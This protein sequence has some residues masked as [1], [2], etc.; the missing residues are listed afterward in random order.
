MTQLEEEK[1]IL[2]HPWLTAY[3]PHIDWISRKVTLKG[4]TIPCSPMRSPTPPRYQQLNRIHPYGWIVLPH[5]AIR[6]TLWRPKPRKWKMELQPEEFI[7]KP[8]LASIKESLIPIYDTVPT[9]RHRKRRRRRPSRSR[10]TESLLDESVGNTDPWETRLIINSPEIKLD[11]PMEIASLL[12][13]IS[14]LS[15]AE[16]THVPE[17]VENMVMVDHN[18][19]E[20][21]ISSLYPENGDTARGINPSTT[22]E[23]SSDALHETTPEEEPRISIVDLYLPIKEGME[24]AESEL[25]PCLGQFTLNKPKE[26]FQSFPTTPPSH[27]PELLHGLRNQ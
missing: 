13:L 18:L 24:L 15:F 26:E 5:Q 21:V 17:L 1:V 8:H 3:N 7:D 25:E 10:S 14:D 12:L 23:S 6:E 20:G 22:E 9:K 19:N 11:L 4:D 2:G 27:T 16:L